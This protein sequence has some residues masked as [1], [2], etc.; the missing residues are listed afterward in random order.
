MDITEFKSCLKDR[1]L[2]GVYVFAGE[3]DYLIRYYLSALRCALEIDPTFAVFNNP[4]F[5]GEEVDFSELS[6]IE[7][8]DGCIE[9]LC[10]I[11]G[12]GPK[13]ASCALLFS[14]ERYDAFPVDVWIKRA[15]Q[16]Y[17]PDGD[18]TPKLFG[19]YAGIAQQYLFYYERYLGGQG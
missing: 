6:K 14:C 18:F 4:V 15:M 3:E 17:F 11:K 10:R 7:D 8:T 9:Y 16:R 5:E 13:V 12:V 1:K 19:A 2:E